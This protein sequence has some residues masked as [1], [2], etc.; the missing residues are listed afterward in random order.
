MKSIITKSAFSTEC[1]VVW[2]MLLT[3]TI[4]RVIRDYICLDRYTISSVKS[5]R[6]FIVPEVTTWLQKDLT[7]LIREAGIYLKQFSNVERNWA[8]LQ[9]GKMPER[10]NPIYDSRYSWI[11]VTVLFCTMFVRKENK[12][13]GCSVMRLCKEI[14]FI[15]GYKVKV[16]KTT[17]DSVSRVLIS[18]LI[19]NFN[20]KAIRRTMLKVRILRTRWKI[21]FSCCVAFETRTFGKNETGGRKFIIF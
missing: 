21:L 13:L 19:I 6:I 17:L 8:M 12:K 1:N 15:L 20:S 2:E 9:N 16:T 10:M 14:L 5:K 11:Y 4:Y 3:T 18:L 7:R